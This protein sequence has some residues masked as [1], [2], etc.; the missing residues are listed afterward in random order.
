MENDKYK[1]NLG[2]LYKNEKD[3]QIEKDVVF[4]EN[5]YSKIEKKYKNKD[6]TKTPDQL[7]KALEDLEKINKT[8]SK[9]NPAW[10]FALRNDLDSSDSYSQAMETKIDQRLTIASNKIT[11]FDLKIGKIPKKEQKKFLSY[12]PLSPFKYH[13]ENIFENAKYN[14]TE[15]EEQLVSLLTQTSYTMWVDGQ[16]KLQSQQTVEHN[17]K[18]IPISEAIS[19]I[20]DLPK[21]ERRELHKKVNTALKNISYFSEAEINS[22]YNFKKV[23]DQIRGYKNPY[24]STVFGYENDPKTIEALI[25]SVTERFSISKRF[26]NLHA[27]LLK[28]RFLTLADR[29]SKI[30]TINKKFNFDSTVELVNKAFLRVGGKYSNFLVNF[31]NN[32]Q[33]DVFPKKGKK[34]GAYCWGSGENA[35]FVLLNHTDD[36]RSVETLAHEMG[37][38]IH[39]ELSKKQPPRYQNYSIATAEVASTFFEQLVNEE[40]EL[41]ISEQEKVTLLHN[42]IMGD[43]ITIFRQIACFNFENELHGKIRQNGQVS[44]Q[45]IAK[46]MNKHLASYMGSNFKFEEDDGYFFVYWSHIRRFFYVYSYAYGQLISRALFQKWKKDNSYISKIDQFLSAGKSMSPKDIFKSIGIDTTDPKFFEEGLRAID[47]DI[48]RLE[49]LAKKLKMI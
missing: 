4:I 32:K 36:I 23:I 25:K 47:A 19:I 3:P 17:K 9:K 1:W 18:Q 41:H 48:T 35:T 20:S 12:K 44:K 42:K 49:K 7:F 43:I 26:Y 5:A 46:L 10:Y 30:G 38:A 22:I 11:F 15:K 14:L 31:L 37:H 33:I 29:N 45:E 13:L 39:T 27:R 40:L 8:L 24:D 21:V 34:S 2:L 16:Q 6:F 28:E